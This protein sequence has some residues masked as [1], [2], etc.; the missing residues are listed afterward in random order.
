MAET[1]LFE[2]ERQP[3]AGGLSLAAGAALVGLAV[4][5]ALVSLV[6]TP[7]DP[8]ALNIDA[9]LLPPS[10]AHPL[11]TD[12]FGRDLAS[13]IL[14]GARASLAVAGLSIALGLGLG[15]PLGLWAA[16]SPG[17]LDE[18]LARF[19]DLVFAFP[20]VLT[21]I[22]LS[23]AYGP[24]AA[25][26]VIAIGVFNVPVFARVTRG[27]ALALW[28]RPFVQAALGAGKGRVSI[29]LQHVLPNLGDVLA[30]QASIQ[31]AVAILA[32]AGLSYL[33]L[34]VQPPTPSWGR[35]LGESQT[36][37]LIAPHL[38]VFPGLAIALTVLGLTLLG[39][40]LRDRL[41]PRLA[42]TP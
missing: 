7:Y 17:L 6:W 32:E 2:A 11:G 23:A 10:L 30:V 42:R 26:A 22:L 12:H 34:G 21:A 16:A 14:A 9:R 4:L 28:A 36:F 29:S 39:D 18:V 24:G 31:L 1:P 35:L 8:L 37:A 33:G 40:G 25:N 20:A 27:A 38:A 3:W 19:S 5:A 13:L 15:V 41:D